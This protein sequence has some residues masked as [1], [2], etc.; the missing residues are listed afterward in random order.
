MLSNFQVDGQV[1]IQTL[2]AGQEQFRPMLASPDLE[3]LRQRV[4]ASFHLGPL[5]FADTRAYVEHRLRLVD[6]RGDPT[7][8]EGAYRLIFEETG[9]IPR[10][11]NTLCSR[12]LL[13][14]FLDELHSLD[15]AVV[16]AVADELRRETA[17][18]AGRH[19]AGTFTQ[20]GDGAAPS[21][22][23]TLTI[24]AL[25][26]RVAVLERYVA[27]HERTIQRALDIAARYFSDGRLLSQFHRVPDRQGAE[28]E[29]DDRDADAPV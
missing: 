24:D 12:L 16:R 4:V 27:A 13:F 19:S 18:G 17:D 1:A 21:V 5:N 6:W 3:Q 11:I 29:P 22:N 8:S 23:D 26:D 7:F 15:E 9:G 28:H 25:A 10:R 20:R 14:G 2:L